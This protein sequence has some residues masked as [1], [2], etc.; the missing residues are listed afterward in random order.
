MAAYI[1]LFRGGVLHTDEVS[2]EEMQQHMQKW[3][4]WVESMTARGIYLGGKPLS[5]EGGRYVLKDGV[6]SDGPFPEAKEMVA[7]YMAI[8][9]SSMD[10][11]TTVAKDCPIYEY[12]G[13]VE[14]RT[15]ATKYDKSAHQN[16]PEVAAVV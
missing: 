5:S 8:D 11:A 7:G 15:I 1:F 2:P 13:V 4:N 10:E 3:Q 16:V 9:V 12:G 14:V 6:V